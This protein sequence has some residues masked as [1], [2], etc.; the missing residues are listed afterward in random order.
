M[1]GHPSVHW[2][3]RNNFDVLDEEAPFRC[4]GVEDP[5]LLGVNLQILL[6]GVNR[7]ENGHTLLLFFKTVHNV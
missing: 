2:L 5:Q 3:L 1:V 7:F 4:V 6:H